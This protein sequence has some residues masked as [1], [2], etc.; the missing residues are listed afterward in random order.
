M[1]RNLE[2]E[3]AR[4]GLT[5]QNVADKL[6]IS[7][8]SYESKKKSGKFTTKE[9]KVLCKLFKRGFD[10]LFAEDEKGA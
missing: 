4:F 1:F 2:A 10:Y 9:I 3:Q 7:R 8:V 5:N 6:G